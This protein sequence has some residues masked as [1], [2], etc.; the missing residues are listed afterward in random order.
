MTIEMFAFNLRAEELAR[1]RALMKEA[2]FQR[3][4]WQEE[5]E[6]RHLISKQ[7]PV[8]PSMGWDEVV[9]TGL[10]IVGIY[11]LAKE[12]GEPGVPG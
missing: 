8:S 2:R 10:L 5:T 4:S 7:G 3:L 1:L 11:A 6:L 12:V 9:H